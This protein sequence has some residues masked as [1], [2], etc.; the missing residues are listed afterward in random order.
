M[1]VNFK[2]LNPK[3]YK[4]EQAHNTDAGFDIRLIDSTVD[5]QNKRVTYNTGLAIEIPKGYAGLLFPRSSIYKTTT[6]LS[7]SVGVIDHGYT[8]EIKAVMDLRT[9][10]DVGMPYMQGDRFLQLVI[11]KL[12]EVEFVEVD[13][14]APSARG[15]GGF[16]STGLK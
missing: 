12:N 3:A 14:L 15:E 7:N 13:E 16:G 10:Q 11:I 9:M 6:R 2:K 1:Q 5:Y 8:G 4:P